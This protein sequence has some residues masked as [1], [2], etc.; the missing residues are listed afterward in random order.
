MPPRVF[1]PRPACPQWVFLGAGIAAEAKEFPASGPMKGYRTRRV[2]TLRMKSVIQRGARQGFAREKR[3][4]FLVVKLG[5]ALTF[6]LVDGCSQPVA[7]SFFNMTL[8]AVAIKGIE[9]LP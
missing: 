2:S 8:I 5:D 9:R 1:Y 4:V 3:L 7:D 6:Q